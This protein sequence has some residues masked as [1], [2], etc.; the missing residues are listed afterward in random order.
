METEYP[1]RVSLED[2]NASTW[3]L[4]VKEVAHQSGIRLV[5]QTTEFETNTWT[6]YFD[7]ELSQEAIVIAAVSMIPTLK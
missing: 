1:Y 4:A 3:I 6:G 2:A 5:H 7:G